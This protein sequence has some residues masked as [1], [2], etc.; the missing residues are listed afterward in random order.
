MAKTVADKVKV[1]SQIEAMCCGEFGLPRGRLIFDV[2][3]FTLA[4]GQPEYIDAGINTIEGIRAVKAALPGVLT[5]LGVSNISF[6]LNPAARA[7]INS[8]FLYHCVEAGLDLAIVNPKDI[9]PYA[10]IMQDE[11]A[12]AE[13][14]IFNRHPEALQR[15]LERSEGVTVESAAGS[16][17]DDD[18]HLPVT[19]RI[20]R[21]IL[22]RKKDGIEALLDEALKT[23]SP[24]ELLNGCLLGA[25]KDVGD[26]FGAGEL[27][28]P[29]VLQ[30]AEV[31]KKA[32]SHVERFLEKNDSYTK[33]VVV[34]A[35]VFGDVHDIGKNLV[36]TILSNN[37]YTVH[38]L[39]KQ[40][41]LHTI[42]EKHVE[43]KADAI[44]VSA[45]LVSTSKQ[46]PLC[47]QYLHRDGHRYPVI[48]GVA[49]INRAY[50]QRIGFVEPDTYY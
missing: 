8:V 28:L 32:V 7:V 41:P 47:L 29:F 37:G 14:L 33:G 17:D 34:L 30:S 1:A 50:V 15:V 43:L 49:A 22:H 39:G 18:S 12:I 35:T 4:T 10:L 3:T 21:R 23:Q 42:I 9:T 2:L 20:H 5:V 38:D 46:M 11:R 16:A 24:V 40:V 25:M 45:L 6:G 36:N 26:K 48:V 13:D 44:G 27:I 31:M 19:E